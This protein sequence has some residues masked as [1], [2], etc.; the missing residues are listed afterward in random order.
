V[1]NYYVAIGGNDGDPGTEAQPWATVNKVNISAFNADDQILFNRGDTWSG[2][3][4]V[5]PSSGTAGH[6]IVFGAYGTGANPVIDLCLEYNDF[7]IDAA[8]VWKRTPNAWDMNQVFEDGARLIHA[9]NRVGM[10]Q[11]SYFYD[12]GGPLVY[13]WCQVWNFTNLD[14]ISFFIGV[15]GYPVLEYGNE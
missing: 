9:A 15:H 7:I 6:P 4:L 8:A 10:V 5:V 11:G 1:T 12:A 2:D 14:T 13:V 3:N